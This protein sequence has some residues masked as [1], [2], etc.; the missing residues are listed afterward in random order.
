MGAEILSIP[1]LELDKDE[2]GKLGDAVANVAKHYNTVFDPKKVAIFQLAV[3][4]GGIYGTRLFAV[5]NRLSLQRETPKVN[6][7][8]P[9]TRD[10]K[11]QQTTPAAPAM[12]SPSAMFGSMEATL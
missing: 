2:A 6:G 12:S 1:E 5:K 9:I 10:A 3:V 4:A 11:P 8:Q 7:P